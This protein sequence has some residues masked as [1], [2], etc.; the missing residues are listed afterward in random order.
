MTREWK[1]ETQ[2]TDGNLK[3]WVGS[4]GLGT[5]IKLPPEAEL[6]DPP[7]LSEG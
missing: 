3:I 2:K 6:E 1:L 4:L 5:V 7:V